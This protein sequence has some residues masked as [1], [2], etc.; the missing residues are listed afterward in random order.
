MDEAAVMPEPSAAPKPTDLVDLPEQPTVTIRGREF[1][2]RE[3]RNSE[4]A[5]YLQ[6]AEEHD[7]HALTQEF[8]VLNRDSER[9]L[10]PPTRLKLQ[11]ELVRGLE[12][13]LSNR[14]AAQKPGEWD[15]KAREELEKLA[16]QLDAEK[17]KLE[18]MEAAH[19]RESFE[20]SKPLDKRL[21]ELRTRLREIRMRFVHKL[22]GGET[23]YEEWVGDATG[24]DYEAAEE[25][26]TVGNASWVAPSGRPL[27]RQER[28]KIRR[29]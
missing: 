7:L 28:R 16:D 12:T 18:P 6:H 8:I 5:L 1:L 24:S 19:Q 17:A 20:G 25:L 22:I 13:K 21:N 27:N 14:V 29:K 4:R 11:R 2:L 9:A 26:I 3:F 15:E 23:T 10:E